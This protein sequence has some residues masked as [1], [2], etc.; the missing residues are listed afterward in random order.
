[1][2][3]KFNFTKS[4]RSAVGQVN[5]LNIQSPNVNKT[6][7]IIFFCLTV[8]CFF[9]FTFKQESCRSIVMRK[10]NYI[11]PLK[12]FSLSKFCES[13]VPKPCHWRSLEVTIPV[14]TSQSCHTI[15][16]VINLQ[17]IRKIKHSIF[18]FGFQL[19]CVSEVQRF[20]FKVITIDKA[21]SKR[22]KC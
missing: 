3:P 4:C 17:G 22:I 8:Q 1:M 12:I 13:L 11:L 6:R 14:Y 2:L 19:D 5:A 18:Y 10:F 20:S 9:I 21:L 7:R 15:I 16:K